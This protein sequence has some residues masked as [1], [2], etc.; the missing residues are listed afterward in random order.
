M[1]VG[2]QGEAFEE[3]AAALVWRWALVVAGEG[4]APLDGGHLEGLEG[5]LGE[6][7]LV[8]LASALAR[9]EPPL[10][11]RTRPPPDHEPAA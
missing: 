8:E 10:L 2:V 6:G 4:Q 9:N 1:R 5:V 11:A 3:G 7:V